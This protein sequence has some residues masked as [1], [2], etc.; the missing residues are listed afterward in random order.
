MTPNF[1]P[2]QITDNERNLLRSWA[3]RNGVALDVSPLGHMVT[4]AIN[5]DR[6][7]WWADTGKAVFNGKYKKGTF[8]EDVM[9]LIREMSFRWSL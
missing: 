4:L 2:T 7:Q 3:K 8:I 6:V 1:R 9:H 5:G